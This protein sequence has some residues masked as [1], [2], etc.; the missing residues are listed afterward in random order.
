[1]SRWNVENTKC[2]DIAE[3]IGTRCFTVEQRQ[4]L[5]F[6]IGTQN[7]TIEDLFNHYYGDKYL[8][9]NKEFTFKAIAIKNKENEG[10]F[11]Q[12]KTLTEKL[13]ELINPD[14]FR[15]LMDMN[16]KSSNVNTGVDVITHSDTSEERSKAEQ[17]NL[18]VNITR[19]LIGE[20]SK[21]IT[22]L[23]D[24]DD[25]KRINLGIEGG[26]VVTQPSVVTADQSNLDY[27]KHTFDRLSSGQISVT[28]SSSN[29]TASSSD[30]T[31]RDSAN[32]GAS[33]QHQIKSVRSK[34]ILEA[35]RARIPELRVQIMNLY[36]DL[37]CGFGLC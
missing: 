2:S 1:M 7:I 25:L 29:S 3:D 10:L 28:A 34:E 27:N 11:H 35:T 4:L 30:E 15:E 17:K 16:Y 37:F 20:R 22:G 33:E 6:A 18:A 24:I 8:T 36:Y 32:C 26:E 19:G 12:L 31:K 14:N 9:F 5:E 21:Q 13:E 23:E